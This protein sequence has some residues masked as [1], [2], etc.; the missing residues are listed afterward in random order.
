M[1]KESLLGFG[2]SGTTKVEWPIIV[3]DPAVYVGQGGAPTNKAEIVL[4]PVNLDGSTNDGQLIVRT[5][6]TSGTSTNMRY[7]CYQDLATSSLMV[8]SN[9]YNG[10]TLERTVTISQVNP[11]SGELLYN[12]V[13]T[14]LWARGDYSWVWNKYGLCGCIFDGYDTATSSRAHD[15]RLFIFNTVTQKL[16]TIT[17]SELSFEARPCRLL[18]LYYDSALNYATALIYTYDS[19]T[20]VRYIS[21]VRINLKNNSYTLVKTDLPTVNNATEAN[22]GIICYSKYNSPYF[23]FLTRNASTATVTNMYVY[24]GSTDT[25]SYNSVTYSSY[26]SG[27]VNGFIDGTTA[28]F[29]KATSASVNSGDLISVNVSTRAATTVSTGLSQISTINSGFR[30]DTAMFFAPSAVTSGQDMYF[31]Y[32]STGD[33]I[34]AISYNMSSGSTQEKYYQKSNSMGTQTYVASFLGAAS[35]TSRRYISLY[36]NTS[37]LTTKL[38]CNTNTNYMRLTNTSD[39]QPQFIIEDVL[40]VEPTKYTAEIVPN[41]AAATVSIKVNN[42][43][44]STNIVRVLPNTSISYTVTYGGSTKTGTATITKNQDIAVNL[45]PSTSV[46]LLTTTGSQVITL[47]PGKYRYIVISGGGRGGHGTSLA[48]SR[49][50][51]AGGGGGGGSGKVSIGTFTTTGESFTF[52]VGA[53]GSATTN[54]VGGTGGT[55]SITGSKIGSVV[56]VAGGAGGGFARVG[57]AAQTDPTPDG[58]GGA[59]GSGGGGGGKCAAKNTTTSGAGGSGGIG[60][61]NG[62]AGTNYSSATGGAGVRNT[63]GTLAN[64]GGALN[65]SVGQPG[66]GGKGAVS[67]QSTITTI[68]SFDSATVYTLYDSMAGGGGGGGQSGTGTYSSA[69]GGGGGGAWTAGETAHTAAVGSGAKTTGGI[70]GSGAILYRRIAWS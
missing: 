47:D 5:G 30:K 53:G 45:D 61:Y 20:F 22:S 4:Y 21:K 24:N 29:T 12:K 16:H 27:M 14:N 34:E 28:V 1:L 67:I 33:I 56:S 55:S 9:D 51:V 52:N 64:N 11:N 68:S 2:G 70:G 17:I 54:Y 26:V 66:G 3:N 50:S 40:S 59:G 36:D 10:S 42:T 38:D 35:D 69:G 37:Y 15:A 41:P 13:I 58:H 23:A 46:K 25:V 43:T 44:Y 62:R 60:G 18:G 19:S 49:G 39:I 57:N 8:V 48:Y 7:Y 65:A 63:S 32:P 31:Y 6:L